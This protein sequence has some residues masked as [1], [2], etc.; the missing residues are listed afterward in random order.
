MN[1]YCRLPHLNDLRFIPA[2]DGLP[3]KYN[4]WPFDRGYYQEQIRSYQYNIAYEQKRNYADR[5][6]I[7]VDSLA[8]Y[9]LLHT[10]DEDGAL[11]DTTHLSVAGVL[12][13]N[14]APSGDA[15]NTFLHGFTVSD[16]IDL[17][18][19]QQ[20]I[21]YFVIEH[22]YGSAGDFSNVYTVSEP[23]FI[24]NTGW[25]DT[26]LIEVSQTENDYDVLFGEFPITFRYRVEGDI[27]ADEMT[28][29]DTVFE[30]QQYQVR[31]LQAIPGNTF[32]LTLGG[33]EGVPAY[34]RDKINRGLCL[35]NIRIDDFRYLKNSGAKWTRKQVEGYPMEI[36]TIDLAPYKALDNTMTGGG[37][38]GILSMPID[39]IGNVFYP[40]AISSL[41][42]SDGFTTHSTSQPVVLE[43]ES[44]VEDYIDWLNAEFVPAEGLGGTFA[45]ESHYIGYINA[46]GESYQP[47]TGMITFYAY[48]PF[49]IANNGGAGG[50]YAWRMH[51]GPAGPT[52]DSRALAIIDWGD[53]TV[54]TA[55]NIGFTPEKSHTYGAG[56]QFQFMRIFHSGHNYDPL[57]SIGMLEFI[58]NT[59]PG[60]VI[61]DFGDTVTHPH[62]IAPIRLTYFEMADQDLSL[63]ANASIDTSMFV[64]CKNYIEHL[65]IRNC[66]VGGAK[67]FSPPLL[68]YIVSSSAQFPVLKQVDIS[69]NVMTTAQVNTAFQN[70]YV[71]LYASPPN[72]V[73][74]QGQTPAAPPSGIAAVNIYNMITYHSWIILHD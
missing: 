53:G 34:I 7:Y 62:A 25:S 1:K 69:Y 72:T 19:E 46:V 51:P 38:V 2:N 14:T 9:L 68:G 66:K 5:I 52:G 74:L 61:C 56:D 27:A 50:T 24:R 55:T 37:F 64:I 41:I 12:D 54:E 22:V 30:D 63:G 39:G 23:V 21:Y 15:Y 33:P 3:A 43:D 35:K 48:M 49:T 44:G 8:P 73:L 16:V 10:L 20:G 40:F 31:N 67:Y 65:A 17:D 26:L 58:D 29:H 36:A 45:I 18:E 71:N 57:K 59:H 47:A 70:I 6:T 13:G 11:L 4:T 60:M 42:M 28:S 32:K